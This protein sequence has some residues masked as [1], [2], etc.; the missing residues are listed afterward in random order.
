MGIGLEN[1]KMFQGWWEGFRTERD[2]LSVCLQV[3]DIIQYFLK[4]IK[5]KQLIL[6][7]STL[8]PFCIFLQGVSSRP[9]NGVIKRNITQ[10]VAYQVCVNT[11]SCK[12]RQVFGWAYRDP[13]WMT[14]SND[15]WMPCKLHV[16][17]NEKWERHGCE[18]TFSNLCKPAMNL[19]KHPSD[20]IQSHFQS[21]GQPAKEKKAMLVTNL[22]VSQSVRRI[23]FDLGRGAGDRLADNLH[24]FPGWKNSSCPRRA[25]YW[26]FWPAFRIKT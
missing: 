25:V 5:P 18:N 24:P 26:L 11:S 13:K 22:E 19:G 9:G 8:T 20:P 6:S 21:F 17:M 15:G 1:S 7:S 16:K 12:H 4:I 3:C 10:M 2:F 14:G 23:H